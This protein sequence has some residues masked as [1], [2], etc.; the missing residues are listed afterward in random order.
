M[1]EEGIIKLQHGIKA[2]C[3]F[4]GSVTFLT[5]PTKSRFFSVSLETGCHRK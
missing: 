5:W 4:V 2:A 1:E 3:G